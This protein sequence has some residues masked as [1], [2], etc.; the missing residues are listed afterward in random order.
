M[1]QDFWAISRVFI[2]LLVIVVS[3]VL[4]KKKPCYVFVGNVVLASFLM[5]NAINYIIGVRDTL[6]FQ[7]VFT[8]V[9]V[10]WAIVHVIEL[11]KRE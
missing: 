3:L 7:V 6:G 2:Y 9:L 10:I 4:I 11:L 1:N 5:M 8:I